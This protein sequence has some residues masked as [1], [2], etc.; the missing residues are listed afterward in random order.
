MSYI[1][2][3]FASFLL[4][5]HL[6]E[7]ILHIHFLVNTGHAF[8]QKHHKFFSS[9][10]KKLNCGSLGPEETTAN[11]ITMAM[12][13]RESSAFRCLRPFHTRYS[14]SDPRQHSQHGRRVS[15]TGWYARC[16]TIIVHY[17]PRRSTGYHTCGNGIALACLEMRCGVCKC[18]HCGKFTPWNPSSRRIRHKPKKSELN[19]S[20]TWNHWPKRNSRCRNIKVRRHHPHHLCHNHGSTWSRHKN[21]GLTC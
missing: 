4:H 10:R 9:M 5:F 17:E 21:S 12:V 6:F 19:I 11:D 1:F 2:I 8:S 14:G 15:P 18:G 20:H 3:L 16:F 7:Q 13:S